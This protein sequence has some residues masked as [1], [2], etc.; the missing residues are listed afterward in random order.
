MREVQIYIQE[1]EASE[2]LSRIDLFDDENIEITSTIQ[3]VKDIA[4]VFTDFSRSFAV[5]ASAS[6]NSLFKHFYNFNIED[7]YDARKYRKAEI[8]INHSLYK[9]GRIA[10]N[11][12]QMKNNKPNSYNLTFFGNLVTLTDILGEDELNALDLTA[13]DHTF[14]GSIYNIFTSEGLNVNSDPSALI[15]PLITTEKRLFYNSTVADNSDDNFDG[16]IYRPSSI[17]G[18]TGRYYKRG[19]KPRDLKP[20]IK[21]KHIINAIETKYEGVEFTSDS[22]LRDDNPALNNLYLWISNKTGSIL[23]QDDYE[24]RSVLDDYQF[25][26]NSSDNALVSVDGQFINVGISKYAIGPF[27][28]SVVVKTDLTGVLST[29]SVPYKVQ[30]ISDIDGS[31]L[32]QEGDNDKDFEFILS[33]SQEQKTAFKKFRIE[34]L[35]KQAQNVNI[36]VDI[37]YTTVTGTTTETYFPNNNSGILT[38]SQISISENI[39]N[40][41]IIDFLSGLFKMFNLT[42]YY[43]DD[44][45]SDDYGKIRIL[46]LDEYYADAVNNTSKGTIDISKYIDITEHSVETSFPFSDINFMF[47][48]EDTLLIKQHRDSFGEIFGNSNLPVKKQYGE[49]ITG[50]PYDIKLPFGHL[51]YERLRDLADDSLTEIQWGYAAGGEFTSKNKSPFVGYDSDTSDHKP[52]VG[53]YKPVNIKALLFYGI[54]ETGISDIINV[55]NDVNN[56]GGSGPATSYYR[57]SNTNEEGSS[58]VAPSHT[59]NF[60]AEVDEFT[61]RDFAGETNSLFNK[62]Y[63]NYITS[64]FDPTKRVFKFT[65]Y[66]PPSFLMKYRLNDQLKVQDTV[67]RINSI[68]TN[69]NSGKSTLEL[70]NLNT[71][72]II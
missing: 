29:D 35:F 40:L 17:T 68:T 63:K 55:S 8:Y 67:Y 11:G 21:L 30:L 2:E 27:D 62:Y 22:F 48:E 4:K 59:I 58:S 54:R 38:T 18:D 3:D 1:S 47:E 28:W 25:D 31:V 10:L 34:I 23:D 20:A 37:N 52:P 16:N 32:Q 42:A 65:A 6:N 7:G 5:P 49:L 14:T 60:D 57:P 41:K 61:F 24:F 19:V 45:F 12:T 72:E 51:K 71:D 66:L 15:Y 44:E 26:T 9:R 33:D 56:S 43:I 53:N 70:I 36:E 50:S 46:T 39:P 69:L 64:V 13:F